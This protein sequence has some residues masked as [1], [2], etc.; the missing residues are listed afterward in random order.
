MSYQVLSPVQLNFCGGISK[1]ILR[2]DIDGA[3]NLSIIYKEI[4]K[5]DFY[6][7]IQD[8]G[9]YEPKIT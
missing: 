9:I 4:F 8:H 3:K 1:Y 6:L 7:E 2:N 5:E